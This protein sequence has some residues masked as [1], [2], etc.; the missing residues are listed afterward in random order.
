MVIILTT[1]IK[2]LAITMSKSKWIGKKSY[3]CNISKFDHL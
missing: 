1:I 3:T 2:S